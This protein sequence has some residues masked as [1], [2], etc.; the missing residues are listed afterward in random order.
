MRKLCSRTHLGVASPAPSVSHPAVK[1]GN[2]VEQAA[3]PGMRPAAS[4]N[5]DHVPRRLPVGFRRSQQQRRPARGSTRTRGRG[6]S[7]SATRLMGRSR[8]EL[9]EKCSHDT[10][11]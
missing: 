2:R 9:Y 1:Q 5:E 8:E 3:V 11:G 10:A 7:P 6:S 4:P